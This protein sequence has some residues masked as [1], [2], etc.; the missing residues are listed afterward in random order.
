MKVSVYITGIRI[1]RNS[2]LNRGNGTIPCT[3]SILLNQTFDAGLWLHL[4]TYSPTSA[5]FVEMQ[6]RIP[7]NNN[8]IGML[9]ALL[10]FKITTFGDCLLTQTWRMK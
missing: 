6:D 3:V 5:V 7:Q 10:R 8:G 9:S 4:C 1:E 2:I